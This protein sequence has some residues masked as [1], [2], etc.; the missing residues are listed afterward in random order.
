MGIESTSPQIKALRLEVEKKYGKKL[1]VPADFMALSD[2]IIEILKQNISPS[3]LERVW[4]YSTRRNAVIS[5]HT[6]NLL[7][8]YI[9]KKDWT[10]FCK[11]LNES[12]IIDSDVVAGEYVKSNDLSIGERLQI[13]WLPNRDCIIEYTGDY[14]FKAI[15][16]EN[17]TLKSGDTFRCIEFIKGQPAIMDEFIQSEGDNKGLQ[18]YIAGKSHGLSFIKR[19]G[20]P[21]FNLVY[22]HGLSS[23]GNSGTGK[24][25]RKLFPER[26]VIT[27]DIPVNPLE[28]LKFLK[29]LVSVLD[30][31]KT[32]IIGTSMGG[33]YAQQLTGFKRIVVNPAFHVSNTLKK[34][35]GKKLPFFSPRKNGETEFLITENLIEDFEVMESRQFKNSTDPENVVALFGLNDS[36]VNCKDEYLKYYKNY[37]DFNGEHRLTTENIDNTL[38]PLIKQML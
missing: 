3:T 7:C 2:R 21:E 37:K 29:E 15:H 38:A 30:P 23:S 5:S 35:L 22:L 11:F 34:N 33:M 10:D 18:R 36:V 20:K 24:Q 27:P 32:I 13:G 31:E 12:G 1:E 8:E 4:N 9:G 26:N 28:A 25:L 17:S 19:I 16:C 6:L 14:K